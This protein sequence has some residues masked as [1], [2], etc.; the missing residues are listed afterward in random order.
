MQLRRSP[1]TRDSLS[2]P[3]PS[4]HK[5]LQQQLSS[6]TFDEGDSPRI[7]EVDVDFADDEVDV[8]GADDLAH[9]MGKDAE[10]NGSLLASTTVPDQSSL[11][12]H[13]IVSDSGYRAMRCRFSTGTAKPVVLRPKN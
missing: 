3:P 1:R 10:A 2:N 5:P 7:S 12:A 11:H 8:P 9:G 13:P 4:R 6:M